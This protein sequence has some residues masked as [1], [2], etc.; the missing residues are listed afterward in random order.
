LLIDLGS[1]TAE[2]DVDSYLS[3]LLIDQ[4]SEL[5]VPT[6]NGYTFGVLAVLMALPDGV[7][8]VSSVEQAVK[9][10]LLLDLLILDDAPH[11]TIHT[12]RTAQA[13]DVIVIPSGL[14]IE[15]LKPQVLVG[16][17]ANVGSGND[18]ATVWSTSSKRFRRY[19]RFRS[20]HL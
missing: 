1:P 5:P 4:K 16:A 6:A 9:N 11:S 8:R 20:L 15:D 7:E 3:G 18:R 2:R 14:S 10:G 13:S 12:L 17:A 19:P